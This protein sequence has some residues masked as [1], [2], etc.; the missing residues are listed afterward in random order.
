MTFQPNFQFAINR[1]F[2]AP[3]EIVWKAWTDEAHLL[4]WWSPKGFKTRFAKVDLRPGGL[5][6]YG[7]ET[8]DGKAFC[9]RFIYRAIEPPQRLEFVMSFADENANIARNIWDDQWPLEILHVV[10]FTEKD[11]KTEVALKSHPINASPDEVAAFEA[12]AASMQG[13]YRGTF[14]NLAELLA[15]RK[16]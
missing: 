8:P 2:D 1:V 3:R 15:Q 13:G 7:L 10:T 5:F 14:D 16:K 4:E 9:G 11:G 12:G 6:H